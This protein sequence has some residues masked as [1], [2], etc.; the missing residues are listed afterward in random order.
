MIEHRTSVKLVGAVEHPDFREAVAMLRGTAK[1]ET[2]GNAAPE[3][4]VIIQERPGQ[5]GQAEIESVQRQ[6]PLAG[7]VAILG[8]WCEGETRTGKP[9]PGVKRFFWYE[10]PAWWRQQM[11]L[12]SAGLCPDW[13][14]PT[15][16]VYRTPQ[17]RNP[18][19]VYP[20]R[21]EI[22]NHRQGL[23]HLS[24]RN[25]DTAEVLA[26]VL[27]ESG[28]SVVW[29]PLGP[30]KMVVRGVVAGVWEGVQLDER[31]MIDLAEFCR[32]QAHDAVPVVA[33][34]D[35]PRRDRCEI[36]QQLGVTA[37][38]GK[39]WINADLVATIDGF[40][41]GDALSSRKQRAA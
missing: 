35:F 33:L 3:V 26:D 13:A 22:R 27:N 6:W 7:I 23:I 28:Y 1:C 29:N 2:G 31:D 14:R 36:A 34:L 32:S 38:L 19:E 15:L 9:W 37:V 10:F 20:L 18:K 8:S 39:P 24:T 40:A 5:V 21:R 12:R 4:V 11:A 16:D 17:I 41:S 30:A 25:R